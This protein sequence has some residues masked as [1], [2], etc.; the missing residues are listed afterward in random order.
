MPDVTLFGSSPFDAIRRVDESGEFWSARDLM[1]LLGYEKWERFADV[2]ERGRIAMR[3]SG[4]DAEKEASRLREAFGSTR[5]SGSNYRLTRYGCYMAAMNGDPRKPEIAAAQT[6]FA[7]K[8]RQ[9]ESVQPPLLSRRELAQMVIDAEDRAD[10]A[11]RQITELEPKAAAADAYMSS[12]GLFLIREAAK[13]LGV[14]ESTLRRH[15]YDR[16]ILMSHPARRNEPYAEHVTEG[17][18]EVKSRPVQVSEEETR[19]FNTTYVT[20]RGVEFLRRSLERAGLLK[21]GPRLSL[22]PPGGAA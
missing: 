18:F 13:T 7:V 11:E 14:K 17:R 4:A 2:V 5:Q 20:P 3:N 1:P 15:C 16:K 21:S 8:T 22:V 10:S 6:Y 19:A 12:E 9:A